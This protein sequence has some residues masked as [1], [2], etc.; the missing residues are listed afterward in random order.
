VRREAL[1]LM[2]E[3]RRYLREDAAARTA[4]SGIRI[5]SYNDLSVRQKETVNAILMR[6]SSRC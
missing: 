2:E 5:M 4:S 6:S 3:C 1:K